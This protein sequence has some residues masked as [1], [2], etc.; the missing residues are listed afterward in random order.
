MAAHADFAVAGALNVVAMAGRILH[1]A[2]YQVPIYIETGM[3]IKDGLGVGENVLGRRGETV[4][5]GGNAAGESGTVSAV[6]TL[7]VIGEHISAVQPR[8]G[9]QL[10]IHR[11]RGRCGI[12]IEFRLH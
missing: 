4:A 12:G 11:Q 7:K 1:S 9:H 6:V 3:A 8:R 5:L 2:G 10:G